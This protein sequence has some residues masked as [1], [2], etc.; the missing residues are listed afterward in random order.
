MRAC[1]C[2]CM[3]CACMCSS[4]HTCTCTS[5][6]LLVCVL[7]SAI[8]IMLVWVCWR[9]QNHLKKIQFKG[10]NNKTKIKKEKGMTF[11]PN[12]C[13]CWNITC[14]FMFG[15][16]AWAK[17]LGT[18]KHCK[19]LVKGRKKL[20]TPSQPWWLYQGNS[21]YLAPNTW[22]TKLNCMQFHFFSWKLKTK[23]QKT[24][25]VEEQNPEHIQIYHSKFICHPTTKKPTLLRFKKDNTTKSDVQKV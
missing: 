15:V 7:A 19:L 2:A 22:P 14:Q 1:V 24:K 16:N 9:I 13:S 6:K 23:K 21:R 3:V 8:C 25:K 5:V 10:E 12:L 17:W 20:F 18:M 11:Y 4:M